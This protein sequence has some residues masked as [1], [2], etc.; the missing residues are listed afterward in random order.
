MVA[1]AANG[2][3]HLQRRGHPLRDAGVL[4][5]PDL[6]LNA[7]GVTVSYFEWLKN[8]SHVRFGRMDKRF[9][10]ASHGISSAA[11]ED[12]DRQDPAPGGA[13]QVVHGPNEEDIVYSGLEETMAVAFREIAERCS[14]T[15]ASTSL[16][17]AAF[18]IAIEKVARDL[19]RTGRLPVESPMARS[20]TR[21]PHLPGRRRSRGLRASGGGA[22][23]DQHRHRERRRHRGAGRRPGPGGKRAGARSPSTPARRPRRCRRS[24]GALDDAGVAAPLV[25]DFHY[26][27]HLLLTEYPECARAL[28]KYRINPGNVGQGRHQ[29]ANFRPSSRW[30]P[31][32]ASRCGSG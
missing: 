6:Y 5:I 19:S 22:V 7:G 9:Q 29:D 15:T 20:T 23:H 10:E 14:P 3:V 4:V 16:R 32:T 28:D 31:S 27:G 2:P 21:H 26:N 13:G 17:T 25:G 11:L 1:E 18:V 24:A 12:A 30:R 8:L